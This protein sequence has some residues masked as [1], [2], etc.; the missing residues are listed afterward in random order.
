MILSKAPGRKLLAIVPG[1][2]GSLFFT[3]ELNHAGGRMGPMIVQARKSGCQ[4]A[5]G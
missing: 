3:F 5:E 2:K 1:I 4:Y